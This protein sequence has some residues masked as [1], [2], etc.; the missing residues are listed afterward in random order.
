VDDENLDGNDARFGIEGQ[1]T[2][3]IEGE[4]LFLPLSSPL[5]QSLQ[6]SQQESFTMKNWL[7]RLR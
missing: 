6:V 3:R 1:I 4:S 7:A 5:R 2:D